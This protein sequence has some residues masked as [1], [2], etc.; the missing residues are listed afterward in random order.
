MN[1][2]VFMQTLRDQWKGA[3][4]WGFGLFALSALI[5]LFVPDMDALKQYE[6]LLATLPPAVLQ[7]FG[8]DPSQ[9]L[10]PDSFISAF[11]FGRVLL[12]VAVFAVLAG[13]NLTVNEEDSG[14]MD[15][16][17]TLPISRARLVLER[18]SAF[19]LVTVTIVLMMFAGLWV[20]A[21][22]VTLT[23]DMGKLLLITL[24]VIFP[25]V[26][27]I[28]LTGFIG[29]LLR[30]KVLIVS[31]V[32]GFI[33]A[34]YFINALGSAISDGIIANI[35]WVSFFTYADVNSIITNGFNLGGAGL[36]VVGTLLLLVGTLALWQRRDVGV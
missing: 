5:V 4:G 8:V 29:V 17:M 23:F 27:M 20:G 24:S 21:Q 16:M 14:I 9:Q 2:I 26:F 33:V 7:A 19:I 6:Q 12:F 10:T 32:A 22:F 15:I 36:L 13:L 30:R 3:L 11:L 25:I 18:F 35:R 28:A 34:S 31:V 1:G